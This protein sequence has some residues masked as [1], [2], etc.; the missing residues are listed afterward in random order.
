MNDGGFLRLR[1][2]DDDVGDEFL[3]LAILID[4]I[5]ATM[6]H[7]G[8]LNHIDNDII[9]VEV[10]G[11]TQVLN[12]ITLGDAGLHIVGIIFD[13]DGGRGIGVTNHE[14]HHVVVVEVVI[15]AVFHT[16]IL[17]G[18]LLIDGHTLGTY[19]GIDNDGTTRSG[20]GHRRTAVVDLV[21]IDLDRGS[22]RGC[23]VDTRH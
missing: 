1:G 11:S 6:L 19:I 5:G 3:L 10:V 23:D 21:H 2:A 8:V 16:D 22:Y 20:A 13:L 14:H 4:G 15:V 7:G 17:Y 9:E 12:H 18:G